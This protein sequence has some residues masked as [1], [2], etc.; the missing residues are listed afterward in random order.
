MSEVVKSCKVHGDLTL[1][2]VWKS[3]EGISFRIRC[4]AC[5]KEYEDANREKIRER[6]RA[7]E[8]TKRVRP[9]AHVDKTRI[10]SRDWRRKNA[11]L[12]N[13]RTQLVRDNDRERFREYDR[14]H[15]ENNKEKLRL[16]DIKKK[17]GLDYEEYMR[18]HLAQNGR[19]KICRKEETRKS[20]TEGNITRLAVDHCHATGKIRGLLCHECNTGLGKFGDDLDRLGA[21]IDYLKES[22]LA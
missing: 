7:Y 10:Y 15:R 18:M 19:C 13:A 16:R 8:K 4:K 17:H 6:Q 14:K 2:Q 22:R 12:V 11:D 9:M 1:D 3:K 20:R 5:K 21:A